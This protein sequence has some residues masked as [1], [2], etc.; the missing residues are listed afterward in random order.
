MSGGISFIS[1]VFG[2]RIL[3]FGSNGGGFLTFLFSVYDS[4]ITSWQPPLIP[5]NVHP[6]LP[7]CGCSKHCAPP[8][9]HFA[10]FCAILHFCIW[11][12]CTLA[13]GAVVVF[14]LLCFLFMSP[15]ARLE[16]LKPP[17]Q[18]ITNWPHAT[19]SFQSNGSHFTVFYTFTFLCCLF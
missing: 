9:A 15:S 17:S 2:Q 5:F 8:C 14:P 11:D 10:Q 12:P 4:A 16:P 19:G 18:A 6:L 13:P 3:A 7:R 1:M